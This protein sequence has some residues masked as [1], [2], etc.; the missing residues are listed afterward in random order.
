[1]LPDASTGLVVLQWPPFEPGSSALLLCDECEE[2]PRA[3]DM[4]CKTG[5]RDA[6]KRERRAS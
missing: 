4:W 6:R 3:H 1:M 5:R 2:D